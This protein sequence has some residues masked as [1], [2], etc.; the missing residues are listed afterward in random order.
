[1]DRHNGFNPSEIRNKI[2]KLSF[3]EDKSGKVM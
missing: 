2:V 3:T 1:M